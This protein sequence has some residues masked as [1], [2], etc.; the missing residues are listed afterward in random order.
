MA[1]LSEAGEAIMC[2][3][4]NESV[5]DHDLEIKLRLVYPVP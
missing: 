2:R 5:T 1:G 3:R 4:C